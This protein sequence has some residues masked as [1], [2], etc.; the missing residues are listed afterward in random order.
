M[1]ST[2]YPEEPKPAPEPGSMASEP[3]DVTL[4]DWRFLKGMEDTTEPLA[5]ETLLL[6]ATLADAI[7]NF[8]AAG[9]GYAAALEA[10]LEAVEALPDPTEEVTDDDA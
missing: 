6:R 4:R 10:I 9:L 1:T 5:L 8:R 7:D 2:A 3:L